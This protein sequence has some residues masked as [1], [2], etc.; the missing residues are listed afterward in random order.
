MRKNPDAKPR[1]WPVLSQR[2]HLPMLAMKEERGCGLRA[3]PR[4][5]HAQSSDKTDGTELRAIY[6]RSSPNQARDRTIRC[7][8]AA[9]RSSIQ[10]R[11]ISPPHARSALHC[12][13]WLPGCLMGQCL[14]SAPAFSS[15]WAPT[16]TPNYHISN[17][18]A[19]RGVR[20]WSRQTLRRAPCARIS[21]PRVRTDRL[22]PL[23]GREPAVSALGTSNTGSNRR[24]GRY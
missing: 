24:F 20:W 17:S 4:A 16:A 5:P 11:P 12:V 21:A 23:D 8:C 6:E 18:A 7:T 2:P 3:P 19:Q 13:S 22:V 1:H 15:I 9:S 10:V 14:G